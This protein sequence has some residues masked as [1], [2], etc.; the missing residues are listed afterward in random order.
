MN[1]IRTPLRRLAPL[2][3][4]VLVVVALFPEA[5]F[6]G[7]VF[8]DR[9]ISAYWLPH[10]ATFVR[11]LGER[12]WPLWNPYEGFGL[13]LLGDPS[14]QV[15]YPTTWL[16]LVLPGPVVYKILL[17]G[18]ALLAGAG[19]AALGRRWGMS[20]MAAG[21]AGAAWSASGPLLS[22]GSLHQHFCGAAWMAWVL[23]ALESALVAPGARSVAWLAAAAA[24]EALTGSAD[25]CLL[26]AV[27]AAG[28]VV[29]WLLGRPARGLRR[30]VA[31]TVLGAVALAFALAAVQWIPSA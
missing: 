31:A 19:V 26:T 6:G 4:P 9:D 21:L 13:P 5:L 24:A 23:R 11:V 1:E 28:R 16:N 29:F 12:A 20:R 15:A 10:A 25:M 7:Q 22:A 14:L 17:A 8:F 3:G 18:H 2:L 27:A 30:S